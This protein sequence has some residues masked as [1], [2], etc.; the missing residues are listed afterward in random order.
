MQQ[1]ANCIV[2]DQEQI[3]V[4]KKPKHG[5]YAIPGGKMEFGE[6]IKEAVVREYK[7]ETNLTIQDPK[8]AGVFTFTIIEGERRIEEWMMYTFTCKS[9]RGELAEFCREGELEWV[10]I[11][12]VQHL[13][14]AEGDRLIYKQIFENEHVVS[15]AFAYTPTDKLIEYRMDY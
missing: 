9:Y 14:M 7:E 13:P 10:P 11:N 1:V 15:G 3:L 4:L 12:H 6:T 5:W 2:I 8:L